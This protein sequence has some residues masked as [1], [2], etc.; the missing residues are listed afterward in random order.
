MMFLNPEKGNMRIH[1]IDNDKKIDQVG[2]YLTHSEAQELRDSLEMLLQKPEMH[3]LHIP[4]GDY[5]K[6]I[7]ISIYDETL[8]GF[9]ERVRKLIKDDI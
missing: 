3:H 1:N 8:K 7:T 6:Q 2:L 9:N 4:N 5:Q